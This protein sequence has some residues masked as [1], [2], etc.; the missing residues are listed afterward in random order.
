[1]RLR[2]YPDGTYRE[3]SWG[4]LIVLRPNGEL[5]PEDFREEGVVAVSGSKIVLYPRSGG[6]RVLLS[7]DAEGPVLLEQNMGSVREYR[8]STE[9]NQAPS[10]RGQ[11][12]VDDR[13]SRT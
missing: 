5:P 6:R 10:Q 13:S 4:P 1:M 3:T 12:S 9:P 7:V 8:K 11:P 2:I